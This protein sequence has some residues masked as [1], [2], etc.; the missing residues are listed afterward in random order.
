M[1]GGFS[2]IAVRNAALLYEPWRKLPQIARTVMALASLMSL[3]GKD[4]ELY[5]APATDINPLAKEVKLQGGRAH[6][7]HRSTQ[8]AAGHAGRGRRQVGPW[9]AGEDLR[10]SDPD[11]S[12]TPIFRRPGSTPRLQSRPIRLVPRRG[13][14]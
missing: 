14:I 7:A 6:A 1:P 2:S 10:L 3:S 9:R 12:V 5:S 13:W 11:F 8:A 4:A